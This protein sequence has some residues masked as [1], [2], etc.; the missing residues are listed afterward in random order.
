M[1]SVKELGL[2]HSIMMLRFVHVC[3]V[4]FGHWTHP[5]KELGDKVRSPFFFSFRCILAAPEVS[6]FQL[7]FPGTIA[8]TEFLAA[9][10]D[11]NIEE[12]K[13]LALA[14]FRGFDLDGNGTI[15]SMEMGR[16][17]WRSVLPAI[18]R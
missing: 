3:T 14:A 6:G 8:Y 9:I 2:N 15:T 13:D 10:M 5:I 12:R 18:K 7:P 11:H 4:S 1:H 16:V 17:I